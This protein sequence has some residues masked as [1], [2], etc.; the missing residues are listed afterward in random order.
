MAST[1]IY[2]TYGL[3]Y[4]AWANKLASCGAHRPLVWSQQWEERW[5]CPACLTISKRAPAKLLGEENPKLLADL[6]ALR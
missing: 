3:Q 1:F 2:N 5:P 6:L 4:A